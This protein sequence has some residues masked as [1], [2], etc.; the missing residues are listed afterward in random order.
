MQAMIFAAGKG[1]RLRPLTDNI[2]KALVNVGGCTLLQRQIELLKGA[3]ATLIVVNVHH[4]AP[5]I[6]SYLHENANFGANVV[7]S[8]ESDEL[9]DTGGGLRKAAHL[10]TPDE[11]V[12][13]HNVD[14]LSNI[15]LAELYQQAAAS[16]AT[17]TLVVSERQTSRYLLFNDDMQLVGWTNVTTGDVRSPYRD[18]DPKQCRRY[19]FAGIHV[20]KQPLLQ[21]MNAMPR[22]FG[23]IDFYLQVCAST[24]IKGTV[25]PGLR[26]L[27]VGKQS[28]LAAADDFI[29]SLNI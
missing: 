12:L 28:T 8:D 21:L 13:L 17:A 6:V 18:I 11:P 5:L 23:I 9:L 14:I 24:V 16:T 15:C 7:I 10:F 4:L 25:I 3:G 27:D 19:A 20:V 2:P 1:T 22:K 29:K 26:L